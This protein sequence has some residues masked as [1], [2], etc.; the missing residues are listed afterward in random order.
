MTDEPFWDEL[1]IAWRAVPPASAVP[2]DRIEAHFRRESVLLRLAIGAAALTGTA[3]LTL[4]VF[5]LWQGWKLAAWNFGARGLALLIIA[6]I[7]GLIARALWPVRG[8][9][10]AR[11]LSDFVDVGLTRSMQG[12]R[13]CALS[14]AVCASAAGL[15]VI[16]AVLRTMAGHPP[17]VPVAV[18]LALVALIAGGVAAER[19]RFRREQ[20]RFA[21]LRDALRRTD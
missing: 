3:F 8:G 11:S 9:D 2:L 15:G 16:G 20:A 14:F 4:G 19:R 21:Y 17:V 12:L 1:G 6:V 5:T 7:M 13:V 18:D 10:N